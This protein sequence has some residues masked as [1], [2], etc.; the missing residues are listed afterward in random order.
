MQCPRQLSE[1]R[2]LF[3]TYQLAVNFAQISPGHVKFMADTFGLVDQ[4]RKTHGFLRKAVENRSGFC[5]A[6]GIAARPAVQLI[7]SG[8]F[9]CAGK[10]VAQL[11]PRSVL[12]TGDRLP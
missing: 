6:G 5:P 3:G 7:L 10:D 12:R 4:K 1:G 8:E 9:V 2:Q 11:L